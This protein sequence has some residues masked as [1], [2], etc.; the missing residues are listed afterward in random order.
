MLH[1][2][3]LIFFV[4]STVFSAWEDI[5]EQFSAASYLKAASYPVQ[6]TCW[7]IV[8]W[9]DKF[10]RDDI[11]MVIVSECRVDNTK[12]TAVEWHTK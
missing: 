10:V 12:E 6:H 9:D 3:T 1:I 7:I 8:K 4:V 2:Y 11:F 5:V